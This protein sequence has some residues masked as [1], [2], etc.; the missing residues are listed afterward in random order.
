MSSPIG[1]YLPGTSVMHRLPPGLKLSALLLAGAGSLLLKT[2]NQTAIA[3]LVVLVGYAVAGIS[4]RVLLVSLRPL[5]WVI[6]PLTVFQTLVAGWERA[7]VIVGVIAGLVLLANLVTLTTRTTDLIDVVVKLSRP[8]RCLGINPDRVGLTLNLAIRGVPL[9]VE[10]A[11]QL[12]EA[13][14]ARGQTVSARAFAV[15]LILGALR[16]ADELGEALAARGL[17]D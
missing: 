7:S 13:Q 14:L 12:R 15:P 6:V 4:L 5:L 3:V 1:L 2:P 16:R 17:D 9:M 8:L 10:L 11:G